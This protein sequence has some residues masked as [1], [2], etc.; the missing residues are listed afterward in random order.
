MR[1]TLLVTL[2]AA[3]L[4]ALLSA[5][6]LAQT[7]PAAGKT[8]E[9][10]VPAPGGGGTGDTIARIIAERERMSGRLQKISWLTVYPSRSNF[11]LCRI[12][13]RDARALQAELAKRGIL[14][15]YFDRPG[16]Q[17]CIR[18]SVGRPKDTDAVVAALKKLS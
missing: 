13:G 8:I 2:V 16:L 6:A 14:I 7:W 17:D 18:I 11:L 15:R 9:M 5:P 1:R 12:R 10:V 4:A 3:L